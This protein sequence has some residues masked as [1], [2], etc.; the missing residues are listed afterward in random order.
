MKDQCKRNTKARAM[1]FSDIKSCG[2]SHSPLHPWKLEDALKHPYLNSLHD[3]S[4]EP[5]CPTLFCFDFEQHAV[6][7]EQM[8]E[9]IYRE[10]LAFDP[11]YRQVRRIV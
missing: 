1:T 9:L 10:S 11:Q 2:W 4:D 7:E 8:K 3:I 6:T 5:T